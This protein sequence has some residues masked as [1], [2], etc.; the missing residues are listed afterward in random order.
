LLLTG[1][2]KPLVRTIRAVSVPLIDDDCRVCGVIY[3][4]R[5]R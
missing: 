2:M 4:S 3:Q 1:W 5:L